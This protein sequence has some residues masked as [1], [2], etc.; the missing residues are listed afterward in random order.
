MEQI[1]KFIYIKWVKYYMFTYGIYSVKTKETKRMSF[2][3]STLLL[4]FNLLLLYC[5]LGYLFFNLNFMTTFLEN[6][7][8][9]ILYTP[10]LA[11][12][13]FFPIFIIKF[14]SSKKI[15]FKERFSIIR[16][17]TAEFKNKK[18]IVFYLFIS[19]LSFILSFVILFLDRNN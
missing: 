4:F 17:V 11:F 15:K 6:N 1:I 18:G 9:K 8:V 13:L 12:I 10:L 16:Q 14:L 19:I 5:F 2:T 7:D 3:L